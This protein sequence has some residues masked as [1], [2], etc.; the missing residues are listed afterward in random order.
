M[1]AWSGVG[2]GRLAPWDA[3]GRDDW[4]VD[5]G[6]S[7]TEPLLSTID[8]GP[9]SRGLDSLDSHLKSPRFP[10]KLGS[11]R[12]PA[13]QNG[14]SMRLLG[15]DSG[16][17]TVEY[18]VI[19]LLIAIIA[20]LGWQ[21]FGGSVEGK[22]DEAEAEIRTM[23]AGGGGGG[24]EGGGGEGGEGGGGGG[25]GAGSRGGSST[26]G[27]TRVSGDRHDPASAGS[28]GGGEGGSEMGGMRG[29]GGG[30]AGAGGGTGADDTRAAGVVNREGGGGMAVYTAPTE[31][32]D[33]YA[34]YITI[35]IIMILVMMGI[36][37]GA[38]MKNASS[39]GG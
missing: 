13:R 34:A 38:R 3:A 8:A 5:V 22:A 35:F 33:D 30:G 4:A 11:V 15:D 29:G 28:V 23:G 31:E 19:L 7:L 39:S 26:E 10:R 36:F 27:V 37:L 12:L 14:T 24:G 2:G 9:S 18:I 25:E 16:L 1:S 6:V 21:A 17:S 32:E 20:V